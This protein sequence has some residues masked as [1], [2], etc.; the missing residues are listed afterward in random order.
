MFPS[1]PI[2][3]KYCTSA[4]QVWLRSGVRPLPDTLT[5][6]QGGHDGRTQQKC[7]TDECRHLFYW[8]RGRRL[9]NHQY[10][11]LKLTMIIFTLPIKHY[12]ACI[13]TTVLYVP[14]FIIALILKPQWLESN[15]WY[16]YMYQLSKRSQHAVTLRIAYTYKICISLPHTHAHV[17]M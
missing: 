1:L 5:S 7:F 11:V 16:V 4:G 2:E 6:L 12:T 3:D 13:M 9:T 14:H 8:T 10:F 17:Y 15:W